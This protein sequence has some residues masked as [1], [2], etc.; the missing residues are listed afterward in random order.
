MLTVL[1]LCT[2]LQFGVACRSKN[3]VTSGCPPAYIFRKVF[4]AT[5][6][7]AINIATCY[8]YHSSVDFQVASKGSQTFI[9]SPR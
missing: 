8:Y 3:G 1:V 9:L 7:K 5:G 2:V 4:G 6:G